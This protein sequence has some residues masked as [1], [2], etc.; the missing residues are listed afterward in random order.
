M[1]E[2]KKPSALS[3][4]G[5]GVQAGGTLYAAFAQAR[6]LKASAKAKQKEAGAVR[7][8][9]IWEGVRGNEETRRLLSTQRALFG[10]AGVRL[11]GAP[12]DLMA[13][14]KSARVADRMQTAKNTAYEVSALLADAKELQKAAHASKVS[15]AIGAFSS[16][17]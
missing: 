8:R 4:V 5:A 1:A 9:G 2:G 17:W 7:E 11:E 16:F 12:E 14:T 3:W 6:S 13:R 10:E 15:G